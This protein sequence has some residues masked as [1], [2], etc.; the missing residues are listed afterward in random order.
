MP[1][2]Q[3][4]D[5]TC[6]HDVY[7]RNLTPRGPVAGVQKVEYLE[8]QT[9]AEGNRRTITLTDGSVLEE[10]IL[11]HVPPSR[12][13]YR[14]SKGLKGPFALLVRSAT[15]TWDY[16]EVEGGTRVDWTYVFEL[17]S[18]LAYPFALPIMPLF[19]AWQK[20]A[21]ESIRRELTT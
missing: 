8:G 7:E 1:R 19:R 20:Q 6:R 9:L 15:G 4:F 13:R 16:T 10:T 17:K 3:V 11:D 21:L 14:W 5:R 12:H 2:A 18:P